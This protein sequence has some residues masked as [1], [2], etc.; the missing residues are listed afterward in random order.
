MRERTL[1]FTYLPKILFELIP[2]SFKAI[3]LRPIIHKN[4]LKQ[5]FLFVLKLCNKEFSCS[6]R[7][8]FSV[9]HTR[10]NISYGCPGTD[11]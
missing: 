9:K 3:S 11:N 6:L 4:C 5:N 2:L 1:I 7:Y 10:G 8:H